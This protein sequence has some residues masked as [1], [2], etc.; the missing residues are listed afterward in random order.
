MRL[1]FEAPVFPRVEDQ[2]ALRQ[3]EFFLEQQIDDV[4][5]GPTSI[6]RRR[7]EMIFRGERLA[8]QG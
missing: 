7:S 1:R 3:E 8:F 6:H 2:D 5:A 4:G